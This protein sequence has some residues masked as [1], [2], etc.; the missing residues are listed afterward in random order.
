MLLVSVRVAECIL[1]H[2]SGFTRLELRLLLRMRACSVRH[3]QRNSTYNVESDIFCVKY[4]N[5]LCLI[6]C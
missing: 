4:L 6:Y 5:Q 1:V 3:G 2:T